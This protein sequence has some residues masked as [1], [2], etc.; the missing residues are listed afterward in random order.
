MHYALSIALMMEQTHTREG[1]GNAVFVAGL[2]DIVVANAAAG[3]CNVFHA[4]LVGTLDVVAEGEEGI[5]TETYLRVLGN[6]RFL[7]LAG[8]G[9]GL[10]LEE[11]LPG[12]VAEN[13]IVV[14]GDIYIDGVV[15]VGTADIVDKG[16]VHHF[17]M[18]A[19]P[20]DVGFVTGQAGAVDTALLSGTDTDGLSV[21]HVADGVGLRIFQGDEG[22]HQVALGLG[23]EFLVGC[24]DIL[25]ESGIVETDFITALFEGDAITLFDFHGCGHVRGVHLNDVVSTLTLFSQDLQSLFGVVRGNDAVAHLPFNQG[26]RS[27]ITSIGECNVGESSTFRSSTK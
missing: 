16:E 25:E 5:G 9:F 2:D 3:L 13:I 8:E 19:E 14:V 15:T 27:G 11:L 22:N 1:H 7:F 21:L 10:C 23:G 20:P 18:L 6:P 17:R 24:G 4:T 26:G 12:A